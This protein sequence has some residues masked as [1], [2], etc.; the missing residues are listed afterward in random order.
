M[1]VL[2]LGGHLLVDLLEFIL[3]KGDPVPEDAAVGFDLL[4][5]GAAKADPAALF[6][7][8]GP[9]PGQARQQ[10]FILG[11]FNLGACVRSNGAAGKNIEDEVVAVEDAALERVL[12]VTDLAGRQ[13]IV[14]HHHV[15]RVFLH[16]VPDFFEFPA[17]DIGS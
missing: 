8:V 5:P 4:F 12:N 14:E 2:A 11:Q 17:A 3:Q 15:N 10:V 16:P 6:L 1:A 13:F 7:Q 9:H